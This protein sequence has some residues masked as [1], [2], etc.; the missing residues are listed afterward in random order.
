M[1]AV[2]AV[3]GDADAP[4]VAVPATRLSEARL[5]WGGSVRQVALTEA[6]QVL[7]QRTCPSTGSGSLVGIWS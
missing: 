4:T 5:L 6:L 2:A 7:G 3:L 1:E